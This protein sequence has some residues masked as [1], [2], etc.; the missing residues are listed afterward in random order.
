MKLNPKKCQFKVTKVP[1]VGHILSDTGIHPDPEKVRAITEMP[2][3]SDVKGL[4]RFLGMVNYLSKFLPLH[5]TLTA[6]LRQLLHNDV[7]FIW[8]EHHSKAFETVKE[9]VASITTLQYYDVN[10]PVTIT[11]DSS[12]D[13]IGCAILQENKPIHYASRALTAS[14]KRMAQIQKELLAVVF[15][16]TKFRQYIYGKSVTVETDHQPLV[17]ILKKPISEAPM[18]LQNL[19]LKLQGYDLN[20]V[21]K[22]TNQMPISDTLSRAY[23]PHTGEATDEEYEV[24]CV[25]NATETRQQEIRKATHQDK[26]LQIMTK[27]IENG[28]PN[29][30]HDVPKSIRSYF[31]L[32]HELV[33]HNGIILKGHRILIPLSMRN[34]ILQQ[35]HSPHVGSEATKT[36]CSRNCVLGHN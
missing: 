1:Y 35:L 33:I 15:A 26:T 17:T 27:L 29:K 5:S 2:S 32:R 22:R 28:W 6:P 31:P 23:L 24:L 16:V 7:E 18:S 10:K 14:E 20:L 21:H 34:E 13:G 12:K 9:A 4:Q 11:A 3:P 25:L 8:D 30:A 19:I 36:S